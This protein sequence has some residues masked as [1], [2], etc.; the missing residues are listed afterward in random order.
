[1]PCLV[2][3]LGPFPSPAFATDFVNLVGAPFETLE[4][5]AQIRSLPLH[6]PFL[7]TTGHPSWDP[8]GE[9]GDPAQPIPDIERFVDDARYLSTDVGSYDKRT[10]SARQLDVA[11]Q[12][13]RLLRFRF[14]NVCMGNP[15]DSMR[16]GST[17]CGPTPVAAEWL[18]DVR[19]RR[20]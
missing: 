15:V 14:R 8:H 4:S 10:D 18:P 1:V 2:N 3:Q 6:L 5:R 17:S 12:S 19:Y 11:R 9:D 20:G 13:Q 16:R 7:D